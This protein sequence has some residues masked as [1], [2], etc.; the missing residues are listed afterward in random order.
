MITPSTSE[1]GSAIINAGS[2]WFREMGR[3][4][5]PGPKIYSISGH[6]EKPG[7]YECPLGTTLRELLDMAGGMKDGIPL[8][9]WTPGG[10]S[11]PMFTAEHLDVPLD[12]EGAAEAGS[13]LGTTAVQVFN[14]T[15]SVPW[16]VM[17][18]TQFYEHESCGKCTPCREGTYWLAQILERMVEGHGT[19][20]D[21]DTLL[22]VCDNILGRSF[23][24][25]GDGAVS[26]IT[27]GI[28]YFR[29]EFLALCEK[30]RHEQTK[31]ELVGAQA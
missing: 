26:P 20:E 13:M 29:E 12:F 8:K 14:E 10:S 16:A 24:A 25:L 21:I 7:Q 15:V 9:F 6:V 4:K 11:T 1:C 17:K 28:K 2:D 19:E 30:N 23:C 27:S 22:D 18:W 31:P 3:E 5:S